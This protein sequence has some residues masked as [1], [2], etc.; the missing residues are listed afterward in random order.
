M[1]KILYILFIFLYYSLWSQTSLPSTENYIYNKNCLNDDC[2]KK[3]ESVQ[4]FDGLGRLKQ[5]VSVKATPEGKDIV[6]PVEYDNYG[7]ELKSY[8]PIPQQTT[9]NGGVYS[10][11]LSVANAVYGNEKIYAEKIPEASPLGRVLQQ[12]KPGNDW[13]NHPA[14]MSYAANS[15]GEVKKY[16]VSTTWVEGRTNSILSLEGTYPAERLYKTTI[17]DEDGR[18]NIEFKN[19]KGQVVLS[20]RNDGLKDI[21]T[22][23][24]YNEYGHRVYV[25][26]PLAAE[27]GLTDQGTVDN[28]C[29][30]Y[31]YDGWNR[32]VEK[33]L[34]GKGWEW[35]VYDKQDRLVLSQDAALRSTS[36][37]F[38][39]RG[40]LF[41]KY[42]QLGR[43]VYSGFFANTATRAAMQ[44]ALNNMSANAANNETRSATSFIANGTDIYYTKNA[45]P[46]GSMTVLSINYYDTYPVGSPASP[47]EI[48]GQSV[49]S[50][51]AQANSSSTK[52]L[53]TASFIKNIESDSWT[54]NFLWY[55]DKARIIKAYTINHMGG[56]TTKE[57]KLD[58]AGMPQENYTYHKRTIAVNEITIR[59]IYEYDE[60]NRVK[61]HWHQVNNQISELLTENVY[62]EL[63]QIVNKKTGSGLQNI[64]YTYN[65]HGS[66]TKINDP[67]M[68]NGKLFGY[69]I[70]YHNPSNTSA[71]SA[72]FNGSITEVDWKTAND[73]VLRRYSYQYDH[74]DRLLKGTYSETSVSV[75]HNDLFNESQSYDSN[76]NIVSLKRYAPQGTTTPMLID[77]LSYTYS[78][79][80]LMK[81]QD[82]TENL[83]GYPI[84][85]NNLSYDV[86]GNMTS[87]VD[88][89]ISS[90]QYNFLNL[91]TVVVTGGQSVQYYYS[92]DGTK[93]KKTSSGKTVDYLGDFQYDNGVLQFFSTGEGYYDFANTRYVYNYTDNLGNIRLS[94]TKNTVGVP[95]ILEENNYY[96]FGMKHQGY[97]SGST[98][99]TS[100]TYNYN[101][102]EM[103]IETGMIDYGWRQYIPELGRWNGIDQL[104]E[105]YISTSTYSYV[106]NNPIMRFDV[107]GRWFNDDGTIDTSGRTPGFVSG[108]QYLNSFLG[109][110]KNDGGG[111][112][113]L[114]II[115]NFIRGDTDGLGNFINSEFTKN[116]WHVI[117]ADSMEDALTKL[118]KY[119]GNDRADNIFINAHGS[120]SE[121]Y[122]YDEGGQLIAD[123]SPSGRNG[124][125]VVGD[126]GFHT[127]KDQILGSDLQQYIFDKSKLSSDKVKSID[128]FIGIAN[129]VKNGKNL[130]IGA[131]WTVRY[132]DLFGVGI[133]SIVK[134]IDVFANRDYSSIYTVKGKGVIPFQNFINYNQTSQKNYINGWVQYRDGVANQHKFNIIMTRYGVKTIK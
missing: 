80:Q 69:E 109:V 66:L 74:F 119:L 98:S 123:L 64:D 25:I 67:T 100:F 111:G 105:S 128:S 62:N 56:Y 102:K 110:N 33:K 118:K 16:T 89:G 30:Q 44:T 45:F 77:N 57:S 86:N 55:D 122:V 101:G 116:G 48:R 2:S 8:L 49:L 85:G 26:S 134:S 88:K 19:K 79:N 65:L 29:Y 108:K 70:R 72:K 7:R 121:R 130:I 14:T 103:Q 61:K 51:D 43:V 133:S 82:I 129:Y 87:H 73:E 68:L 132:D 39:K 112:S 38:A 81:V 114:N 11:P 78:G 31:R 99:N 47:A 71:A 120:A 91:A 53:P 22:Y 95:Q 24:I 18:T 36:N 3:T 92:A 107:D 126:T 52:T 46:T 27:S 63:S 94:Y 83:S 117:D 96:P 127:S 125:K 115:I 37:N 76:G 106:S 23:Y 93:V 5:S 41:T 40:W 54:K 10:D 84:G 20:R 9:Q 60:N 124:Y 28:L 75:P 58:F 113:A 13:N 6:V 59:E 4:Y 34:P 104:A 97:N 17:T 50:E 131:C 35:M 42:D 12:K 21:D 32:L 15:A 90:I 1:K